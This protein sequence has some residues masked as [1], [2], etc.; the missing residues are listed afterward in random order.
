MIGGQTWR[1]LRLRS[2]RTHAD[3]A[4]AV[5][6]PAA[7]VS[8]YAGGANPACSVVARLVDELG[9]RIGFAPRPDPAVQAHKLADVL[10]LAEA[11]ASGHA[12]WS[13]PRPSGSSRR[14]LGCDQPTSRRKRKRDTD[15]WCPL[16]V[17]RLVRVTIPQRAGREPNSQPF[18]P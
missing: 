8:A 4:A 12:P 6:I 3:V 14:P 9:Y 15:S 13:G 10:N 7:V 5:G 18:D 1:E 16:S 17:F 2:G 11:L